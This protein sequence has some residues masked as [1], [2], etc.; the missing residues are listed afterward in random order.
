M[1]KTTPQTPSTDAA[2]PIKREAQ[3]YGRRISRPLKPMR[4]SAMDN[5]LPQIQITKADF[6]LKISGEAWLEIGFGNGDS[7]AAWHRAYP[8]VSFIGCEPFI[9]GVSNLCKLIAQ[10][11]FK[12]IRIWNDIMQP[13]VEALP[14]QSIDRIYLLNSDPWPK[15]KHYRRRVIQ[16]DTLKDLSRILKPGGLLTMTTDHATLADWMLE[17]ALREPTLEWTA[18]TKSDWENPPA[19]WLETR[20]EGKGKD[21]GRQQKYM[22]FKKTA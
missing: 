4:Q 7:L 19:D 12:N 17:H 3:F 13:L 15:K 8:D 20:Y 2:L 16:T 11:D 9:N 10:D 6:P 21:A 22:I 14:D 1:S 5:V 18:R